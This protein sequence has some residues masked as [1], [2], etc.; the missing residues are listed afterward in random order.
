MVQ[1]LDLRVFRLTG[2]SRT[3]TSF[4]LACNRCNHTACTG[5]RVFAADMQVQTIPTKAFVL[6]FMK[7]PL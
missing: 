3:Q 6:A 1:G 7:L 4:A 5:L 2:S